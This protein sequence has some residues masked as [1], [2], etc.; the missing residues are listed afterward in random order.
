MGSCPVIFHPFE[1]PLLSSPSLHRPFFSSQPQH[2][3]EGLYPRMWGLRSV[4]KAVFI[5]L[6]AYFPF[7]GLER[8]GRDGA[9]LLGSDGSRGAAD[10]DLLPTLLCW[11]PC[12]LLA[13]P[14]AGGKRWFLQG[15]L[16]AGCSGPLFRTIP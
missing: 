2:Q 1:T 3:G 7:Q 4:G 10:P 9:G 14:W 16:Q 13:L 8:V 11:P 15:V 12:P 6:R 5:L